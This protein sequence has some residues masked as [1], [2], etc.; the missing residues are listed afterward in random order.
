MYENARALEV[1]LGMD[2]EG[3]DIRA[4]IS[5]LGQEWHDELLRFEE[6]QVYIEREL[7][8]LDN[9][10]VSQEANEEATSRRFDDTSKEGQP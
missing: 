3:S 1:G 6:M 4:Y 8:R 2:M 9:G 10:S 5:L 7:A